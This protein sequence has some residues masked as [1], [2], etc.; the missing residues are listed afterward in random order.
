[1]KASVGMFEKRE[2]LPDFR[3]EDEILSKT[4]SEINEI[5]EFFP[6]IN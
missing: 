1:M 2:T 4:K 6:H 3:L 5:K